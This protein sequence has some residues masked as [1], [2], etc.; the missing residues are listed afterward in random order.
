MKPYIGITCGHD[1]D[2]NMI[3]INENYCRA[4]EA[5]GGSPVLIPP[6]DDEVLIDRMFDIADGILIAGGPDVDP[7][8]FGEEPRPQNGKISP[9][10]DKTELR[11]AYKAVSE[12]KPIFGICRG[13]QVLNIAC[14]GSIYQ[15][16]FSQ[17]KNVDVLKHTQNAPDW[18]GTHTVKINKNSRLFKILGVHELR[19]NSFHHQAVKTLAKGFAANAYSSDGIIEGIEKTG[20]GFAVGVQWH[21]E[22][23]WEKEPRFL[24][25]FEALVKATLGKIK[26]K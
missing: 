17:I 18:Y 14:G 23:M 9:I 3:Y 13:M 4:V 26:E 7:V 16:I 20:D 22:E 15:D 21:P 24:N 6:L 11:L 8:F 1:W 10:R 5:A 12:N 19:V 25:L 2:K